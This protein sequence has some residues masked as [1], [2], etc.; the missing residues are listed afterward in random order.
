MQLNFSLEFHLSMNNVELRIRSKHIIIFSQELRL[1]GVNW[2]FKHQ[3]WSYQVWL[4][5]T[6]EGGGGGGRAG[7]SK[8][9]QF[10]GSL[11]IWCGCR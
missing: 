6:I 8:M 3:D 4:S 10:C 11:P 9:E 2:W 5:G 7:Y 1:E